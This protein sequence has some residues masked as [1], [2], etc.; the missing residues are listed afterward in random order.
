MRKQAL[1]AS[2]DFSAVGKSG[3]SGGTLKKLAPGHY[4]VPLPISAPGDY[5]IE[6]SGERRGR[7]IVCPPVGYILPYD[8]RT[9]VTRPDFNTNLLVQLAQVTGGKINPETSATDTKQSVTRNYQPVRQ[10]LIVLAFVLF[11]LEI[12]TR[13]LLLS[14]ID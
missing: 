5:R 2:S 3:K 4:Q 9:E 14:E 8:P 12:V 7:R 11:L 1:T 10:P 6:L 13:G